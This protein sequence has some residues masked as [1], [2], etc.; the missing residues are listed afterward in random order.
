MNKQDFKFERLLLSQDNWILAHL[1]H[2]NGCLSWRRT[3]QN[4]YHCKKTGKKV[5]ALKS[6]IRNTNLL[7][8]EPLLKLCISPLPNMLAQYGVDLSTRQ[9]I[10]ISLS[11][12]C[13]IV[14]GCMKPTPSHCCRLHK[15]RLMQNIPEEETGTNLWCAS[16]NIRP[17][18]R[19][20]QIE[21]QTPIPQ[22]RSRCTPSHHLLRDDP[23]NGLSSDWKSWTM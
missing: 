5:E 14:T 19:P 10:N 15:P 20:K 11:E 23:A 9:K 22:P 1:T 8:S 4:K 17:R 2:R 16:L 7:W 12:T 21:I 18:V 13:R 6:L 3:R